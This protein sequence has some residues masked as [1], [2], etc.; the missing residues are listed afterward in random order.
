MASTRQFKPESSFRTILTILSFVSIEINRLQPSFFRWNF[1]VCFLFKIFLFK[2]SNII[3]LLSLHL[4]TSC[5]LQY[6][7]PACQVL[8]RGQEIL[9]LMF[10]GL[11]VTC[12]KIKNNANHKP[13]RKYQV[14]YMKYLDHTLFRYR[15]LRIMPGNNKL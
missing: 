6:V 1:V 4:L 7:E 10:N 13:Y 3:Y 9:Y 12:P 11:P 15:I 2:H 8:L 5:S 14:D